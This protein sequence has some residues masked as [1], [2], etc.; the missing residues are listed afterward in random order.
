MATPVMASDFTTEDTD[1]LQI[2]IQTRLEILYDNLFDNERPICRLQEATNIW[3]QKPHVVNRRLCG[4]AD[5]WQRAYFTGAT[6]LHDLLSEVVKELRT[7]L[8]DNI[9][10]KLNCLNIERSYTDHSETELF[11]YLHSVVCRILQFGK[12]PLWQQESK[13]SYEENST[14]FTDDSKPDTKVMVK[15]RKLFPRSLNKFHTTWELILSVIA[16]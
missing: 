3:L 7:F 11:K 4:T 10:E 13:G 15:L 6:S 2:R 12:G 1:E 9:S 8:R 16:G 5:I 14:S